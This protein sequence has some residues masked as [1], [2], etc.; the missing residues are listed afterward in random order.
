MKFLTGESIL[1][2]LLIHI[3]IDKGPIPPE[4][5]LNFTRIPYS[6]I[7]PPPPS[8]NLSHIAGSASAFGA[9]VRRCFS[10]FNTQK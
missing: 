9:T 2:D 3:N 7:D 10:G 8:P 6:L 4:L 1:F 5:A